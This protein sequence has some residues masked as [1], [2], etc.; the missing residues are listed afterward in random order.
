MWNHIG[1]HL[2]V[3]ARANAQAS[4]AA[5][6]EKRGSRGQRESSGNLKGAPGSRLKARDAVPSS[7]LRR[8]RGRADA[9][10][11]EP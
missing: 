10:H 3:E 9:S 11:P 2:S 8:R 7:N 1:Q 5:T 6:T 4:H